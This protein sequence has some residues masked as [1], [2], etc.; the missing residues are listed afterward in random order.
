M[1]CMLG[2][3]YA[4][5][6]RFNG[7]DIQVAKDGWYVDKE[8]YTMRL[9]SLVKGKNELLVRVPI[10][11]RVSM[12]NLFLLGDF[13]VE[14]LG[15]QTKITELASSITFDALRKQKLSFYGANITYKIPFECEAGDLTITTDYYIGA[16][17]SARLDGREIG[18]IVIPPYKLKF[19]NIEKGKHVLELTLFGTRV[20]T[21][22]T[23]HLTTPKDWKG[24][25]M[26][27]SG[28]N[29]WSYEYCLQDMGL[30]KKPELTLE[31]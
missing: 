8:I 17:V 10:S 9:P 16:L 20:N 31:K 13:G 12:E 18:K 27:Y 15:A 7:K 1:P 11:A 28:N 5:S 2:Y 6:V 4:D 23:L 26:W 21:F 19:N 29:M 25:D 30:M 22:G 3:E 14:T 24:P